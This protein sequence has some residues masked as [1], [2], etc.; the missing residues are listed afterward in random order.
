MLEILGYS[1][2]VARNG[3]EALEV[4][5]EHQTE[6]DLVILD[7]IM[8]G[9]GGGETY[10]RLKSIDENVRGLLSSGY[11]INGQAKEILER[12]C[13]GF[14]QKPFSLN[15]LSIKVREVLKETD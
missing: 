11:A 12:G 10:D 9:M 6:I 13:K 7:M 3:K 1:V 15:E 4:Y 2:L 14:I 8:P 5:E